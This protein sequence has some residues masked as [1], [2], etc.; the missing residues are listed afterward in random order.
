MFLQLLC[1]ENVQFLLQLH[2]DFPSPKLSADMYQTCSPLM[3]APP[4]TLLAIS[5]TQPTLLDC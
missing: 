4:P 1:F 3:S 2:T 5:Q